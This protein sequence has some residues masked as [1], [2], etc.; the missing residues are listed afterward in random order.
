MKH[1]YG[2]TRHLYKLLVKRVQ[3]NMTLHKNTVHRSGQRKGINTF[4]FVMRPQKP[5][6]WFCKPR[7]HKFSKKTYEAVTKFYEHEVR[8]EASSTPTIRKY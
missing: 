7:A 1:A 3:A 2:Q 4:E 8:H 6:S 5:F